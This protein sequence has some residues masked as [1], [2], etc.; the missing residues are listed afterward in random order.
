VIP[1]PALGAS[2]HSCEGIERVRACRYR[3]LSSS[4][5]RPRPIREIKTEWPP[6][7]AGA[8]A[9]V[10]ESGFTLIELLGVLVII[11]V[12]LAMTVPSY[13]G[14]K[15]RARET[16]A[17]ADVRSAIPAAEVLLL[18]RRQLLE[19]EAHDGRCA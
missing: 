6:L 18:R 11:G 19:H 12:L 13:L 5:G 17:G 15:D 3:P 9:P 10:R 7:S 8:F 2:I 4:T 14:F 16:A 1:S